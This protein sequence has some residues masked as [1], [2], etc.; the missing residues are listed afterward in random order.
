MGGGG[1][2]PPPD[3]NS[4]VS[5]LT[6]GDAPIQKVM[7]G[8]QREDAPE[9]KKK[10]QF[11]AGTP[12]PPPEEEEFDNLGFSAFPLRTNVPA[13][14]PVPA[15]PPKPAAPA[16]VPAPKPAAPAPVP[17][18]A[19]KP[20]APA[21]L[22][23]IHSGFQVEV[24]DPVI[25]EEDDTEAKQFM[26]EI[27]QK[28]SIT[29]KWNDHFYFLTQEFKKSYEK[30]WQRITTQNK[31]QPGRIAKVS[32]CSELIHP[33]SQ[34][35]VHSI[36]QTSKNIIVIPPVNGNILYFLRVLTFLYNNDVFEKV[37]D[38][39]LKLR[40]NY[41]L[42]CLAPFY[43]SSSD[44]SQNELLYLF[45]KIWYANHDNFFVLQED[46][47]TSWEIGCSLYGAIPSD[48]KMGKDY[49][50]NMLNPSYLVAQTPV[51]VHKGILFST[52]KAEAT[53]G[54][55]TP[56]ATFFMS[57]GKSLEVYPSVSLNPSIKPDPAFA[58]FLTFLSEGVPDS[59]PAPR[60]DIPICDSLKTIFYDEDVTKKIY[61]INGESVYVFRLGQKRVPPLFCM[62]VTGESR[63]LLPRPGSFKGN[64]S[65]PQ[66]E[67]LAETKSF[68]FQ[69]ETVH[70]RIPTSQNRVRENWL[71]E[72]FSEEESRFLTLLNVTPMML[73]KIFDKDWKNTLADFL[74]LVTLSDCFSDL[75]LITKGECQQAYY[76]LEKIREWLFLNTVVAL[77]DE[78]FQ[79]LALPTS[80]KKAAVGVRRP[81]PP[82]IPTPPIPQITEIPWPEESYLK[83]IAKEEYRYTKGMISSTFDLKEKIWFVDVKVVY[84]GSY[85]TMYYRIFISANDAY[86]L[87]HDKQFRAKYSH[88]DA[89]FADI[90]DSLK[91]KYKDSFE[92][93]L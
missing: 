76:F 48:E 68:F 11:A 14:A 45:L 19:P 90:L 47:E 79:Q 22:P 36:K 29:K 38:E 39:F 26:D 12:G 34:K 27:T 65:H 23:P 77:D 59:L 60:L 50:L 3:Y 74:E 52:G 28:I 87:S 16:P 69:G 8:G 20:A 5:L 42:V 17:A 32:E 89:L 24:Y 2:T 21:P 88:L 37:E 10:V 9:A 86:R 43:S 56:K 13:P 49:L 44:T 61:K 1:M 75:T 73:A 91:L 7:G 82:S 78:P 67:K 83:K 62:D 41:T 15:A 31:V 71:D 6:G 70:I 53:A 54:I 72:I 55:P 81:P 33:A 51:S 25:P 46:N 40:S 35:M 84:K 85:A 4:S 93:L 66:Y 57:A 80:Q 18:P 92:F 64:E 58:D 63:L 30:K